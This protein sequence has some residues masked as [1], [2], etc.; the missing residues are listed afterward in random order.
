MGRGLDSRHSGGQSC[1][2]TPPLGQPSPGFRSGRPAL[3]MG[4]EPSGL[5]KGLPGRH[6]P[7]STA[8][9]PLLPL[10]L[11]LLQALA[12]CCLVQRALQAC[13][14][15]PMLLRWPICFPGGWGI[16]LFPKAG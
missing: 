1:T 4:L 15:W 13:H 5:Q 14:S 7:K 2:P 16:F 6:T 9:F 11:A 12:K 10:N 8:F 3:N